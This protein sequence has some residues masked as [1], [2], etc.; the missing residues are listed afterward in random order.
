[1]LYLLMALAALGFEGYE[2]VMSVVVLTVMISVY[3]H[4]ITAMPL[5]RRYGR[6]TIIDD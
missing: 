6:T 1:V 5:S 3:A 2:R 4:G